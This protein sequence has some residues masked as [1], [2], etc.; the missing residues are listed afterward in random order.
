L[1][2]NRPGG[3]TFRLNPIISLLVWGKV[4]GEREREIQ[5]FSLSPFPLNRKVLDPE[6]SCEGW[7]L[8]LG[9]S[10]HPNK[11]SVSK[12]SRFDRNSAS[13]ISFDNF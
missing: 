13:M 5:T 8:T 6:E 2:K 7:N 4:K 3:N 1:A 9:I 12:I 10:L 11:L